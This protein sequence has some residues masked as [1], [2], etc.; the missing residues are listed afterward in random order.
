MNH[1]KDLCPSNV[2]SAKVYCYSWNK[3]YNDYWFKN[4]V[5][6]LYH[7]VVSIMFIYD[8]KPV[9]GETNWSIDII[10]PG[11]SDLLGVL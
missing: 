8:M 7:F 5:E 9:L 1:L 11:L 10:Y 6:K 4:T 2:S 3:Q